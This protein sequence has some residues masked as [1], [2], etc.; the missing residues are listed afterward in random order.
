MKPV[1]LKMK[2]F[3]SYRDETIDFAD[4]NSGIFLITGDTGAGKTTIFDAITFALYGESSGGKR[5][6]RMMVSQYARP[7][8]YTEVEFC[9]SCGADSY[10][11]RRLPEQPKYK[12]K[13]KAGDGVSGAEEYEELKKPRQ[14]EVALTLPDGKIF[15][16]KIKETNEK[17]K[18]IV[19]VDAAQF[20]QIAMLAQGDF[21]KL[22]HAR[23]DERKE[24]FAKLFDTGFYDAVERELDGR[25]RAVYGE[26]ED[27]RKEIE[28]QLSN[29][30]CASDSAFTSEWEE[31]GH[32]G[33]EHADGLLALI[34]AVN[35]EL[36]RRSEQTQ[37][38]V[39]GCTGRLE[40][41]RRNLDAAAALNRDFDA[42][43]AAKKEGAALEMKKEETDEKRRQIAQGERAIRVSGAY[44]LYCEKRKSLSKK[45]EEA[46][47]SA[48]R[49]REQQVQRDVCA[50]EKE[51]ADGRYDSGYREMTEEAARLRDALAGYDKADAAFEAFEAGTQTLAKKK[52]AL[53]VERAREK[54]AEEREEKLSEEVKW[55]SELVKTK[56]AKTREAER[57]TREAADGQELSEFLG[58]AEAFAEELPE[59]Q[60]NYDAAEEKRRLAEEAYNV[61]YQAF[62]D[63]QAQALRAHLIDGEPCPVC[64][65]VHHVRMPDAD[66]SGVAK[67]DVDAA[68]KALDKQTAAAQKEK[69]ALHALMLRQEDNE[70]RL[71]AC[72][73]RQ[74]IYEGCAFA[75]DVRAQVQ[76]KER[77]LAALNLELEEAGAAEEA[78][79]KKTEELAACG[80][81]RKETGEAAQRLALEVVRFEAETAAKKAAWESLLA[82]L[83]SPTRE[84]AQRQ[85]ADVTAGLQKLEEEKR[86]A[87]ED[88]RQAER[89]LAALAAQL[90]AE[91]KACETL[92]AEECAG[93]KTFEDALAKN[94]FAD[95]E[96]FTGA[97]LPEETLA[98][99]RD[100]VS[101]YD[102]LVQ[103][104]RTKFAL[105]AER[106]EGKSRVDVSGYEAQQRQ[107]EEALA[108]LGREDKELF[109]RK[110]A[111]EKAR[112]NIAERYR[113]RGELRVR[114]TL[115]KTL[116]DTAGGK[117][118]RKRIDFQTYIQRHY[119]GQVIGAANER[120]IK[121]SGNQFILRC[122]ELSNLGTVGNV[123]LDLDVYDISNDRI[124]D[125]K[126][127]SGGESFMAALAMALGLSDVIQRR[128]GKIRIDT[129]FIDEG[130]GTLSDDTRN[131][132]LS[133]LAELSEGD[134]LI[135]IISHVTELKAQVD[136]KLVV[137]KTDEGSRA[138]WQ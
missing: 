107:C 58:A 88:C 132:A 52:E 83:P 48:R 4:V 128:A 18:E 39:A 14:P 17:I 119:F 136:R 96:A 63:G 121:M 6:G 97:C 117:L 85:L 71:S 100:A 21:L 81:A 35:D 137:T 125:V 102:R 24:I 84:E 122:R 112:R 110:Q 1:Y 104:N 80:E 64:G 127:L 74:D 40:E 38:E 98:Q 47:Q 19:G 106:T 49:V 108:R 79:A 114:Y 135:G 12:K 99:Q 72:R 53:G 87:D 101:E 109:S 45:R 30:C 2:A 44:A 59:Q 129:M 93:K 138:R 123:G 34:D 41:I 90:E 15:D 7:T 113:K 20:A 22:L 10:T 70:K 120:L 5:D 73:K 31:Q 25:F 50:K 51:A 89:T 62:L 46:E 55:L 32:F 134:R 67:K 26:L 43:D 42:L 124:R 9:F 13:A 27:N 60:R 11:V 115:L 8:E 29:I 111:N 16:G 133:L 118:S 78:L 105:L 126:T 54:T 68:K 82:E 61:R 23:S 77:Q 3:G 28:T 66:V 56:E 130:F 95:E 36:L 75:S 91:T 76:E 33:E 94:G 57:L 92:Q 103:E 69:E 116:N 65:S 131:Q 37:K 86:N